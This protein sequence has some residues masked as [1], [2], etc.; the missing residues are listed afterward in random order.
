MPASPAD[1]EGP[2]SRHGVAH[3]RIRAAGCV[4]LLL[5]AAVLVPAALAEGLVRTVAPQQRIAVWEDTFHPV[6]SLGFT[7]QPNLDTRVNSGEGL[8]RL[9]TDK[10]GFR[11]SPSGPRSA[12]RVVLLLGDSFMAA[13]QVEYEKSL[14][15]L[16]E[17]GLTS[18]VGEPV[19]VRNHA[20]GGWDPP[21][22]LIQ[23]R[24]S[25]ADDVVDFV[26]V[27]VYLGNDVVMEPMEIRPAMQAVRI[28]P[29]R[30]PRDMSRAEWVEAVARPV[31][32]RLKRRSHLY[33]LL[34]GRLE[35]LRIRLG[36]TGGWFPDVHLAETA[37][38]PRWGWT[39]DLLGEIDTLARER[40]GTP[41][42]F[43]LVPS[44]YQVE[45]G[46]L[47]R[48]AE[49]FG[50]DLAQVR[51]DQPNRI[52]GRKM[53][54]RG[55]H[56]VDPLPVLRSVASRSREPLFGRVDTHLSALGHRTLWEAIAPEVVGAVPT[57]RDLG[58][59]GGHRDDGADLQDHPAEAC[60][61]GSHVVA[62]DP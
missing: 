37:D 2:G 52:L 4:G 3:S 42:L 23:A 38:S 15:S 33:L 30:A 13:I 28:H 59:G 8:V 55:L 48:H 54:E 22:Y 47:E 32:D 41:A 57:P 50:F 18:A 27:S 35:L 7:F 36:L 58:P 10:S 53:E 45:E 9:V 26:V 46:V 43:F 39:V 31:D 14:A 29:F 40:T 11:I 1:R 12:D 16:M 24:R 21:Q 25:L 60:G 56:V 49:A 17:Q 51:V 5:A 20:V 6:D 62:S 34:R 19:Q 61:T 44:H